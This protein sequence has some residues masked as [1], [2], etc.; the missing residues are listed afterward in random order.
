MSGDSSPYDAARADGREALRR[1][2]VHVASGV[3][4]RLGADGLSMRP[5]ARAA[6]CS[7]MVFYTEFTNKEGVLDA[8]S[9]E[10]AT[11]LLERIETVADVDLAAHRR[12]V[13]HAYLDAA[14][15]APEHYRVL[16]GR[17]LR[18]AAGAARRDLVATVRAR[19]VDALG[20]EH[21]DAEAEIRFG[22]WVAL[23]GAA[24]LALD[25]Q[26]SAEDARDAADLAVDAAM[27]A[28]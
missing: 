14:F 5:L 4:E 27:A 6:G 20:G 21:P 3:L 2:L 23:H 7:T 16:F 13:A 22:L 25:A 12:L 1:R 28:S 10:A 26:I 15:A 24:V 9:S 11:T 17:P 18:G 8:L 19:V